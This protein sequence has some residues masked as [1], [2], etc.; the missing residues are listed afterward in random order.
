[1]VNPEFLEEHN[2]DFVAHDD[3]PYG[4]ASGQANDV[5]DFVSNY[6]CFCFQ[7]SSCSGDYYPVEGNKPTYISNEVVVV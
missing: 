5:Y 2:I 3:L 4:D 7:Y 6:L 1:M